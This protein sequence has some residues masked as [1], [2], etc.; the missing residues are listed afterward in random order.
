[1]SDSDERSV[2]HE[3]HHKQYSGETLIT[4]TRQAWTR[5]CLMWSFH[6]H[7]DSGPSVRRSRLRESLEK[8]VTPLTMIKTA[9]NADLWI[10][11]Q[12]EPRIRNILPDCA[13]QQHAGGSQG[14]DDRQ[15]PPQ[16]TSSCPPSL[17]WNSWCCHNVIPLS[18]RILMILKPRARVR[19]GSPCLGWM[20]TTKSLNFFLIH[21]LN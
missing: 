1:M 6:N 10:T 4:E 7:L 9:T 5:Y 12:C 21:S 14:D 17:L 15:E 11:A 18:D 2:C 8:R 13:W 20:D 3:S 16:E 19:T